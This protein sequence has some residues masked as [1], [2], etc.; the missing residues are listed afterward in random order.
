MRVPDRL[1]VSRSAR[2]R[3]SSLDRMIAQ[4]R[5]E[6]RQEKNRA[7][8]APADFREAERKYLACRLGRSV[9]GRDVH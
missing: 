4:F 1:T 6:F 8:Y 2:Q 7:Y 3:D 5:Q 9:G